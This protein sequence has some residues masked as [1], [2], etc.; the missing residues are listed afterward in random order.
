MVIRVSGATRSA[1][2]TK[3]TCYEANNFQ[4]IIATKPV[5]RASARMPQRKTRLS[6]WEWM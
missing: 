4:L 6:E 5:H 1:S 2:V 3:R